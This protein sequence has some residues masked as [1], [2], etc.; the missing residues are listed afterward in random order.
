MQQRVVVQ[1]S[2]EQNIVESIIVVEC[3][4][5]Y[6][7]EQKSSRVWSSIQQRVV[8]KQ[9]L[10]QN[11]VESSRGVECGAECSREQQRRRVWSRMQQRVVEEQSV[12]QNVVE[13]S[14][15]WSRMGHT[16]SDTS[17]TVGGGGDTAPCPPQHSTLLYFII[18]QFTLFYFP[19]L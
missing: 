2:V 1:Q 4:A 6:S 11:L 12:E 16:K 3:G 5:E 13:S 7:R 8:E 9:S 18:L 15:V 17:H 10:D 19:L 14:R